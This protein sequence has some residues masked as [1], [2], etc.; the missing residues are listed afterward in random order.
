MNPPQF[1]FDRVVVIDHG[2]RQSMS[3][4]GFLEM[5]LDTRIH[6]VLS[7]SVEFYSGSH[8]V[9][10]REALAQLRQFAVRR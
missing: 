5:P 4:T 2:G 10:R 9:D 6:L 1:T 3:V 7:R 8:P